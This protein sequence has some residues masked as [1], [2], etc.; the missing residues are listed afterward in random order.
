[1]FSRV[2]GRFTSCPTLYAVWIL[3]CFVFS[4]YALNFCTWAMDSWGW[5]M[6]ETSSPLWWR[7]PF[8]WELCIKEL[9]TQLVCY[10]LQV[11]GRCSRPGYGGDEAVVSPKLQAGTV[12]LVYGHSLIGLVDVERLVGLAVPDHWLV[13]AVIWQGL[14]MVGYLYVRSRES[15][16]LVLN[17][18]KRSQLSPGSVFVSHA[19]SNL[20]LLENSNFPN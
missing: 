11:N 18:K 1:M 6:L 3:F 2:G 17:V 14:H 16:W 5:R 13:V 12:V 4:H 15:D 9:A 19:D 7:S 8:S 20:L 10:S